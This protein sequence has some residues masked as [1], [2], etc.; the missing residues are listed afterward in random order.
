MKKINFTFNRT[1]GVCLILVLLVDIIYTVSSPA[2]KEYQKLLTKVDN[3]YSD[4]VERMREEISTYAQQVQ[5]AHTNFTSRLEAFQSYYSNGD[6][7]TE[8]TEHQRPINHTSSITESAV[9]NRV[10]ISDYSY[11]VANGTPHGLI[12]GHVYYVGDNYIG[13]QIKYLDRWGFTTTRTMYVYVPERKN[14]KT[15][16]K[17]ETK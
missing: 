2:Y 13:E 3:L 6:T 11:G 4:N 14:E 8:K 7:V 17:T 12:H 16:T 9:T 5:Q 1:L 10:N 15:D